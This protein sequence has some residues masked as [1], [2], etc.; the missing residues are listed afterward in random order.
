ML[1]CGIVLSCLLE[2]T[3][4]KCE[5]LGKKRNEIQTISNNIIIFSGMLLSMEYCYAFYVLTSF[6]GS[7]CLYSYFIFFEFILKCLAKLVGLAA[8]AVIIVDSVAGAAGAVAYVM[9]EEVQDKAKA[10]WSKIIRG[11]L[12]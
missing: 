9:V 11:L 1:G 4:Y 6:L 10:W 7:L 12:S 3:F 2:S 5:P 8:N